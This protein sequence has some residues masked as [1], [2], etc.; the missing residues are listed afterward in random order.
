MSSDDIK[1]KL[2]QTINLP[3]HSFTGVNG[4]MM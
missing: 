3:S 4:T 1:K 2:A